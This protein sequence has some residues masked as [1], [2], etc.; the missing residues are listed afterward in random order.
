MIWAIVIGICLMF[1]FIFGLMHSI[2]HSPADDD[3]QWE[4]MQKWKE[5]QKNNA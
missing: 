5:E 4:E 2:P 1:V 3:L